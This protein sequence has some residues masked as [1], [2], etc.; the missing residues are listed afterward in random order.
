[1]AA[2]TA[3]AP[4]KLLSALAP[5]VRNGLHELLS[6]FDY[7]HDLDSSLWEFAVE[8]S[9][10]F[11][12]GVTTS[13][14]RWL[15]KR[16]YLSHARE[17]TSPH[18]TERRFDSQVKSLAFFDNTCFVLT[19]AG[20]TLAGRPPEEEKRIF[21]KMPCD[22]DRQQSGKPEVPSPALVGYDQAHSTASTAPVLLP[23]G[24]RPEATVRPN[25]DRETR[26]FV[27]GEQLVKHFRVPSPNQA[28]VLDAFQ[29]EGWPRWVDDPLSPL[30]DQEPKRR[31]RDTIKCLNQHQVS[32]AIRFHGDGT[33][34]RVSWALMVGAEESTQ[35]QN[36][37]AVRH[38]G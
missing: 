13:D 6:A 17:I 19:P 1:M 29:E 34:Q 15:I 21:L 30:P 38:A 7:A 2:D 24:P 14:L 31:L 32:R 23:Y 3:Q 37:P 5:Q 12:L 27:V 8:I 16:G 35:A 26:R 10:L 11:A 22:A 36:R 18:D 33:G 9:R 4:E 20:L 28:A 25:W